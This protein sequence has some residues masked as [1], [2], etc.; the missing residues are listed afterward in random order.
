MTSIDAKSDD[1]APDAAPSASE[2]PEKRGADLRP[3]MMLLPH[4]LRHKLRIVAAVIALAAA[5]GASLSLPLAVRM[6]VDDG[7]T[8]G[9]AADVTPYFALLLAVVA[10][11]ALASA[12][13]FYFVT[14]LGE[15][16]VA[17]VRAAVFAHLTTLD[18]KFYDTA[19]TGEVV[20]RLTA[21]TTQIKA[22]VGSAAS[23]AL[24]N[25]VLL[26]GALGL[27]LWTSPRLS[28][29]VVLAI[30]I[31]A[32]PLAAF[33]RK[34]RVLSRT[35]QDTLADASA[36]GTET[37][38]AVRTLQAF[39]N[40]PRVNA[41]F[42]A[43]VEDAFNAA[44]ASIRLRAVL[45][46]TLMFLVFASV[47]AVLWVGTQDVFSGRITAGELAQFV[48]Y[49]VFAASALGEIAQVWGEVAAA[50]GAT[51]RLAE[52]LA[53]RPAVAPPARPQALPQPIRG[54][55]VFDAVRFAYPTRPDVEVL[56]GVSFAADP[57]R[58]TA[59]VGPSG[60]GKSTLFHL[61]LRQ[62]DP[63]AGDVTLDGAP[64]RALDPRDLRGALGLVSQEPTVFA[65]TIEENIRYGRYAATRDE[66]RAAARAAQADRFIADMPEGYDTL[67][68]ER[69][70][71]LS[72][73][74]RQRVAVARAV[75]KD[76]PV[77]L[78]DEATSS[79]DAESEA[80]VQTALDG[81][82]RDRTTLVIAH[83]LATVV[84]ADR[85]LVMDAGRIVETGRHDELVER[86][87]LYA[88]LARLQLNEGSPR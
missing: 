10:V 72:G 27:M 77:L 56:K 83:R 50:A 23:I 82:M 73:G 28:L 43:A 30:P 33:I 84:K 70:V 62:Y 31:I 68:G 75:L 34:V 85:I 5:A 12:T 49:A 52:L 14:W 79:L 25:T 51:E 88:R 26:V 86:G 35:A 40:E 2:T 87:G 65:D 24:R 41:R 19:K 59:I 1:A 8:G 39:T 15:R 63:I 53:V 55:L 36:Y 32:L 47:T 54:R 80:L 60:A 48:L 22:A 29:F 18:A 58:T 81:L 37:L 11:L 13:R 3:L 4:L 45:T 20:S 76:A 57:G 66:I 17:D 21:D 74:Q 44:R 38:G 61:L 7:F 42:G 67:V 78:L 46:A 64:T 16:V 6:M 69:G 9:T 71:T